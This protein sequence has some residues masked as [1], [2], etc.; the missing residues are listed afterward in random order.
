MLLYFGPPVPNVPLPLIAAAV[1]ALGLLVVGTVLVATG[2]SRW[3]AD[4]AR[5]LIIGG[6]AVL[7]GAAALCSAAAWL[8]G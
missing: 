2:W 3:P 6:G 5:G 8:W 4:T 1:T 7:A